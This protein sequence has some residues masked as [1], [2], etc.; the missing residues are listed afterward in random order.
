MKTHEMIEKNRVTHDAESGFTVLE[1]A[2]ASVITVVSLVFLASLFSLAV[3]QNRMVKQ[4]TAST[5]LAQEKM[6]EL[7][8]IDRNDDRLRVGGGLDAATQEDDYWENIFVDDAG[9]V[10]VV[11]PGQVANY[12]RHWQVTADPLLAN[13]RVIS[14]RV[15]AMYATRGRRAEG[16]TLVSVRSW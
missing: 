11:Q 12:V 14:V 2:V 10:T 3:T 9:A 15:V 7:N 1:V 13:T 8:A 6:E 5:A 16:T 4:F